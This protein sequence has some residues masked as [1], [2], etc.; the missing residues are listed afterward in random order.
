V[1]G[2]MEEL[3]LYVA[4]ANDTTMSLVQLGDVPTDGT[5][6]VLMVASAGG[7]RWYKVEGK[8][9]GHY[10]LLIVARPIGSDSE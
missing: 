9:E 8:V 2:P 5:W 10:G 1:A 4:D 3:A 6:E 7:C